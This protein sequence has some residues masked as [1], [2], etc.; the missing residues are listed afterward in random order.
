MNE[1]SELKEEVRLIKNALG[2]LIMWLKNYLGKEY[3]HK[4]IKDLARDGTISEIKIKK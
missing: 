2:T 3:T 1:L 4:L